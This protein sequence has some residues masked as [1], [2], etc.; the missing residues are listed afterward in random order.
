M[1]ANTVQNVK[2]LY[3]AVA[4][5]DFRHFKTLTPT[6]LKGLPKWP[7]I[8]EIP[9]KP[10]LSFRDVWAFFRDS[11]TATT[12]RFSM[13]LVGRLNGGE[14]LR[15]PIVINWSNHWNDSGTAGKFWLTRGHVFSSTQ[16][17]CESIWAQYDSSLVP[18]ATNYFMT[19]TPIKLNLTCDLLQL[20][21]TDFLPNA[22]GA[23]DNWFFV[24]SQNGI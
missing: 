9:V 22:D 20:E 11:G 13:D 4:Q 15:E 3:D 6:Q 12:Y 24:R 19:M 5:F 16:P 17:F 14:V 18:S 10:E 1:S 2:R 23:Y 8:A 21:I 7:V